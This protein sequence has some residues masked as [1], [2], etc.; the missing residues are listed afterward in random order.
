M[1]R[2]VAA[3]GPGA[4][5]FVLARRQGEALGHAWAAYHLG[6]FDGVM[7][8]DLS[9]RDGRQLSTAPPP[10]AASEAR[11]MVVSPQGQAVEGAL[12][13]FAASASTPHA[14][15]DAATARAY[16]A[17]GLEIERRLV[18]VISGLGDVP[19][20]QILA[21]APGFSIVTDHASVTRTADGR[22]H[23]TFPPVAPGDPRPQQFGY[24]IGEIV[25]EPMAVLPGERRQSP[26]ETLERLARVERALDGRDQPG[27]AP[28]I[29][30]ADLL[31][32]EDGWTVTDLGG[33]TL[34]GQTPVRTNR[35]Y[36]QPTTGFPALG[37]SLLQDRVVDRLPKGAIGAVEASGR[38]FGMRATAEFV[39][40]FTGRTD[41]P[42]VV[43]PFLAPIPD[44]DDLWGYLRFAY[45]HTVARPT[46]VI[47]NQGPAAFMVKN[48]L[49]V[50]SRPALDRVLR[51]LRPA[52]GASSTGATT[53]S[54]RASPPPS[55][56]CWSSTAAPSP[57][58]SP[59][60]R[61]TSTPRSATSP[62]RASTPPP[63]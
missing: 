44:V 29:S 42:D 57:R 28:Q 61:A 39:R 1:A 63:C 25:V 20:K 5:A 10:V 54:A 24:L 12:P 22:L 11:A 46:G 9:A 15:L 30:L 55:D 8:L 7:W 35:A 51:A 23:L 45:A 50:A 47:L 43:V 60:S 19:A 3:Q 31:P 21:T 49:A 26:E 13:A 37:L 58:T 36:V 40:A 27:A 32:A 38:E 52:A 33:K 16:G 6:G 48:G 41:V 56:G 53:T 2:T 18:F 14:L 62:P 4:A 34:V 59:S 17:I